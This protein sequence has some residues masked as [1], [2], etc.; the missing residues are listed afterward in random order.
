MKRTLFQYLFK[1]I[2]TVFLVSLFVFVF[3]IMAA[4][5]MKIMEMVINQ[6][7]QIPQVLVIII[8]M[9]PQIINF[10]LPATCL[11]CVLL[12]FLRLSADNE[13]IA[14]NSSG[15]SLYQMLPSVLVFAS[16]SFIFALF[17]SIY[18]IPLGNSSSKNV[19]YKAVESKTDLDI[20]E[21]IFH[22]PFENVVFYVN[23]FSPKDRTM[24]DIFVMDKQGVLTNHTIIAKGGKIISNPG[25]RIITIHFT[26]VTILNVDKNFKTTRTI[27]TD[28]YDF[29]IDLD[30]IMAKM[31]SRG[32]GTKEMSIRELI[33]H[34]KKSKKDPLRYNQIGL[35]LFEMFSIP[36]AVFFLGIIGAPLGAHVKSRG[37]PTGIVLSLFIFLVYYISLMCVRYFCEMGALPPVIGVWLPDLFLL[38]SCIYLL[39]RV[40]NDRTIPFLEKLSLN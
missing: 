19:L 12:T 33:D 23:H 9:L 38:I 29:T 6:G 30:E 3:V 22:E 39:R 35:Q 2:C 37:R 4:E 17:T 8:S 21:R 24:K 5:M 13:V 31:V 7:L 1:E 26:D 10:S 18:A 11:M 25:Q 27:E 36:V 32:K 14:L 20:K 34:R 15:I 40:A 16:L 28:S